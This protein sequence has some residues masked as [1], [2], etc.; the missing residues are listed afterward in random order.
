MELNIALVVGFLIWC[1]IS[2][3]LVVLQH[4]TLKDYRTT[5]SKLRSE[6]NIDRKLWKKE[7]EKFNSLIGH[8][9]ALAIM[10]EH[11]DV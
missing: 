10:G 7:R 3:I 1:G 6:D 11:D 4:L 5:I 8:L 2:T 9:K